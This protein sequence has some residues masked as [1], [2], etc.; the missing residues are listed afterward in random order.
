MTTIW[1]YELRV[2]DEQTVMMP[3]GARILSVA[4]QRGKPCLWA[5]VD[6]REEKRVA[7]TIQL[8]GTGLL[9]PGAENDVFIGTVLLDGGWLVYHVFEKRGGLV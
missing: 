9:A 7:R 8:H 2:A 4:V 5:M 3:K 1:K 6:D